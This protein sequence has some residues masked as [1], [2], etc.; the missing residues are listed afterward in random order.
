[1]GG[2]AGQQEEQRAGLPFVPSVVTLDLS[3]MLLSPCLRMEPSRTEHPPMLTA[4][5][6]KKIAEGHLQME[7]LLVLAPSRAPS[8][9]RSA[10]SEQGQPVFSPDSQCPFGLH[11]PCIAMSRRITSKCHRPFLLISNPV[12][13]RVGAHSHSQTPAHAAPLCR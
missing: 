10:T 2:R 12:H 8:P 13:V 5:E 6:F 3:G 9:V 11:T 4:R 7:G 1:M